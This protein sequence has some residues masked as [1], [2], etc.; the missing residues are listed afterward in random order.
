MAVQERR[1]AVGPLPASAATVRALAEGS[2][3]PAALL[4][5]E[6]GGRRVAINT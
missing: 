3:L 4:P 1:E 5:V 6:S 2:G